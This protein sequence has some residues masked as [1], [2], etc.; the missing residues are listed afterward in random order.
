M[1]GYCVLP[2]VKRAFC[3]KIKKVDLPYISPTP[4]NPHPKQPSYDYLF[5]ILLIGDAGVGKSCSLVRFAEDTF[6]DGYIS[7]IGVDF[8]IQE[9]FY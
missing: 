2:T 5:K 3:E 4:Q 9:R 1:S 8:V 7:T 6:I